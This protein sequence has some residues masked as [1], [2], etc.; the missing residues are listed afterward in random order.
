V[1]VGVDGSVG[2]EP[3]GGISVGVAGAFVAVGVVVLV[4]VAVSFGG[5]GGAFVA[6]GVSVEFVGVSVGVL[7]GVFV[8][9]SVGV[10]VGDS[11]S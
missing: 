7:V 1:L 5:V 8:G 3:L 4:G 6:V 9:V 10:L 2:D 11:T